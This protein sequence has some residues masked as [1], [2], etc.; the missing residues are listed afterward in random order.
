MRLVKAAQMREMDLDATRKYSIPSL[1][2]ME[3]AGLSIV[4]VIEQRFLGEEVQG[5]RVFI[6]A[7]PGNNGGDGFVVGRHLFNRGAFVSFLITVPAENYR[8]DAAVNLKIVQDMGLPYTV[9]QPEN[10]DSVAVE[11]KKADLIVDALFGTGFKGV[12]REPIASLIRMVNEAGKPVVAVDIPSGMEADTGRISGDCIRAKATVT[13]GMPK[14]GLFLDPGAQYTGEVIVGD[15]SFPPELKSEEGGDYY[16]LD[17]KMVAEMLPERLPTSHKGDFGH[18]AVI[19]GTRGYTG[20]VVLASN[21]ALRGGAGLVTAVIPELCYPIVA[22]KLTEAMTFPALGTEKGGFSSSALD[23]IEQILQRVTVAAIGPGLGQEEET[24]DFLEDLLKNLDIPIVLDA[25]ALNI[26]AKRSYLLSDQALAKQRRNWV[27]T[28]HP[29]EMA[30]L[31]NTTIAAIQ[32]DR[33]GVAAEA[34]RKWGVVLVLKG[35]HTVIAAPEGPLYINSTGNPGLASGGTGD[36]L[37]GLIAS[38]LAQGLDPLQA[39]VCGPFIHGLAADR[40]AERSG[41]AGMIAGDLL[42]EVAQVIESLTA[43]KRGRS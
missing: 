40:I 7:G 36:V 16:L 21:A 14:L 19:G 41:A 27:L 25:D 38:F 35:A 12:P 1:I 8:G 4:Q 10:L 43:L 23:S 17:E 6:I 3:N 30:R 42:A 39:A 29:G 32:E 18:V 26:I 2:L 9:L 20:A 24:A 31:C 37:A 11:L 33:V 15:I 34:S 13:M 22:T 5:K 28:P